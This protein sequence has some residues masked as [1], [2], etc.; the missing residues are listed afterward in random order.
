MFSEDFTMTERKLPKTVIKFKNSPSFSLSKRTIPNSLIFPLNNSMNKPI[1]KFVSASTSKLNTESS[2]HATTKYSNNNNNLICIDLP[3]EEISSKKNYSPK[4]KYSTLSSFNTSKL[5]KVIS[6]KGTK[7]FNSYFFKNN[8]IENNYHNAYYLEG[9]IPFN[10][11]YIND[12]DNTI[13]SEDKKILNRV[14]SFNMKKADKKIEKLAKKLKLKLNLTERVKDETK[15]GCGNMITINNGYFNGVNLVLDNKD[16]ND[17]EKQKIEEKNDSTKDIE[18]IRN[19]KRK[20]TKIYVNGYN[21]VPKELPIFLRDKYNIK[22][23]S[24]MSP[25]CINARDQFLYKKIFHD[26]ESRKLVKKKFLNNKLNLVYAENEEQ[27]NIKIGK[28]NKKMEKEGKRVVHRIKPSEIEEKLNR[29][30]KKVT[31]MKKIIDYAYPNMVL[32][33]I[34]ENNKIINDVKKKKVKLMQD[35]QKIILSESK[36]K[37]LDELLGKSINIKKLQYK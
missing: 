21:Y 32:V 18:K 8:T 2:S 29:I 36:N 15:C 30:N 17:S 31:F 12:V 7:F 26:F 1:Y 11:K 3:H 16:Y 23:T 6:S 24:I 25:F 19:N 20:K 28:L 4:T 14:Q 13:N 22:G 9:G 34:R 27:C 10:S 37:K 5:R 35:K 33:R